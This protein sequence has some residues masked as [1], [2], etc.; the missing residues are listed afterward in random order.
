VHVAHHRAL[1][2]PVEGCDRASRELAEEAVDIEG[3][4][5]AFG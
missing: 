1:R 2:N 4:L 3:V 5:A